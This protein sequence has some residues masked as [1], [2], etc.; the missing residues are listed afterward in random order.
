MIA[1]VSMGLAVESS[2]HYITAF[3]RQR[4]RG[5]SVDEALAHCHQDVGRAMVFSTLALIVGFTALCLSEFVPTIY[6]GVLEGLAM[7]GG[8]LG[9]LFILP[10]LLKLVVRDERSAARRG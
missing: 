10:L 2:V 6:F 9:N 4:R 3:Q 1:S 5:L 7:L 8:M